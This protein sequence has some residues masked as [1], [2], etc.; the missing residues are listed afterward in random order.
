MPNKKDS[1]ATGKIQSVVQQAAKLQQTLQPTIHAMAAAGNISSGLI[2]QQKIMEHL[3][4]PVVQSA[5]TQIADAL[6]PAASMISAWQEMF[7]PLRESIAFLNTEYFSVIAKI[8][9]IRRPLIA[10]ETLG[11]NQYVHW[12]PL[13]SQQIDA[14]ISAD[15]LDDIL[16]DIET[17][18]KNEKIN[19]TIEDTIDCNQL[20]NH[21]RLYEQAIEAYRRGDYDIAMV[22]M[23]AVID[24]LLSKYSGSVATGMKS[25]ME[26]ICR[27]INAG[28]SVKETE[29][30]VLMLIRTFSSTI[31]DLSE[32][33]EFS[34]DEPQNLN[35]HWI[36]HGRSTR[37]FTALDC[38]K[39]IN[40]IYGI[41]LLGSLNEK[42]RG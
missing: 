33:V 4:T 26:Q 15:E 39:L 25:R 24:G 38:M 28:I 34:A 29:F 22:G 12:M 30:S 19:S 2:K 8:D 7:K 27:N 18:N 37:K 6:A 32:R 21:Q 20:Q 42:N 23:L 1:R 5:V 31:G 16:Y 35:R 40:C 9:K 14:I 36:M 13:T 17:A 3:T 10:A 41:L 11:E